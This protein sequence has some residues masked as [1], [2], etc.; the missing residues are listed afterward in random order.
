MKKCTIKILAIDPG[1]TNTGWTLLEYDPSSGDVVVAKIGEFHPGPTADRAEYREETEKF[2]KRTISLTLLR[3]MLI[4]IM[5]AETPDYVAVEDIFFNPQRPMAHAALA[6][7]HCVTRMTCYDVLNKPMEVIQTKIAKQEITGNGGNGKLSVQQSILSCP[8]IKFKN[9]TV[10]MLM[11]EHSADAIAV[12][13]AFAKRSRERILLEAGLL[14][15][16]K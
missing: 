12:G 14:K 3:Q 9:K 5:E 1:L 15:H 8:S 16:S 7:W 10:E 2:S 4:K 6:M 13:Y 11:D